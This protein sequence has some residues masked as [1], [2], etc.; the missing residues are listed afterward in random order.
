MSALLPWVAF[1]AVLTALMPSTRLPVPQGFPRVAL[2]RPSGRRGGG[3]AELEWVEVLVA[4]LDGG[5]DPASS[6]VIAS[7]SHDV[8]PAAVAAARSGGDIAAA[9]RAN[10]ASSLL[11]GVAAC[12]E[13]AQ[14]SGAGLASSLATLADSARETERI[15]GELRAGLAEPRATA[16]VLAALPG[17]GLLLGAGLGADPWSWLLGSSP[18]RVV[19]AAGLV[20]EGVGVWWSWRIT[21][22]LE[23]AL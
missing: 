4:E 7:S 2:P 8:C 22:S 12:W 20:L 3:P 19:L 16:L 15:R 5:R 21:R 13:V 14:G 18:G 17:L 11:R 9:L 6:L 23:G 1:A 10:D